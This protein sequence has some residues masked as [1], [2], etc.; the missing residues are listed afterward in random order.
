MDKVE[1]FFKQ[2]NAIISQGNSANEIYVTLE[3]S[4]TD[5]KALQTKFR[6]SYLSAQATWRIQG[7]TL[8]VTLKTGEQPKP[9]NIHN[10]PTPDQARSDADIRRKSKMLHG[11]EKDTWLAI[12][13]H[14]LNTAPAGL[15]NPEHFNQ[16]LQ[17]VINQDAQTIERLFDLKEIIGAELML[18]LSLV[19]GEISSEHI[20]ETTAPLKMLKTFKNCCAHFKTLFTSDQTICLYTYTQAYS[21]ILSQLDT[22]LTQEITAACPTLDFELKELQLTHN[23]SQYASLPKELKDIFLSLAAKYNLAVDPIITD[24]DDHP[25]DEISLMINSVPSAQLDQLVETFNAKIKIDLN[26]NVY[27][28]ATYTRDYLI[29]CLKLGLQCT[30]NKWGELDDAARSQSLSTL[31]NT[32]ITHP[33]TQQHLSKTLT[34]HGPEGLLALLDRVTQ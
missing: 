10:S 4:G 21:Y 9:D 5:L 28:N 2:H 29:Q 31:V 23:Q 17:S 24:E 15:K 11:R 16:A 25:V 12:K 14:K 27:S 8:I 18:N 6:D 7:K 26:Q 30:R 1:N 13:N 3:E 22:K 32:A 34:Y 33:Q 19:L 20:Q